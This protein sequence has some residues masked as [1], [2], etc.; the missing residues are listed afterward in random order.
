MYNPERDLREIH[1]YHDRVHQFFYLCIPG[2]LWCIEQLTIGGV[3]E[4]IAHVISTHGVPNTVNTIP[5]AIALGLWGLPFE[6]SEYS[7]AGLKQHIRDYRERSGDMKLPITYTWV[8][9][10]VNTIMKFAHDRS[11]L[12]R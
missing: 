3:G 8:D 11:P 7:M 6:A 5:L 9:N 12:P 10:T 1:R 2:A 4:K